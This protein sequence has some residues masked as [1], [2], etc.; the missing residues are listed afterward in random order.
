MR[1]KKSEESEDRRKREEKDERLVLVPSSE[2]VWSNDEHISLVAAM[3]EGED[4]SAV[5]LGEWMVLGGKED[6][7]YKD[8]VIKR[9]FRGKWRAAVIKKGKV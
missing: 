3:S 4:E 5:I 7:S 2:P 9:T 1:E 8:E 6:S